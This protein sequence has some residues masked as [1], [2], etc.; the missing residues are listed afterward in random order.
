MRKYLFIAKLILI[1]S[2][3]SAQNFVS[4]D[5]LWN[6]RLLA[7][8]SFPSTEIFKI[9][10]DSIQNSIK[11]KKIW[12]SYD[13]TNSWVYQGL[14]R[15]ESNIV[16]FVPPNYDE[17]VLYDFNL[18]IGDTTYVK[19]IFCVD[20]EVEVIVYD[21]DTVTYLGMPR[22][23][24]LIN[25]MM[26]EYWIEGIGSQYGPL[27]SIYYMCI[28]CPQWDLLCYFR[29]EQLFYIMPGQ[30]KCF[31]TAVG[32]EEANSDDD[33]IITPNPVLKGEKIE[34]KSLE[35]IKGILI[36]NSSGVLIKSIVDNFNKRILLET[37]RFQ[38]GIYL[39]RIEAINNKTE[40]KRF[41]II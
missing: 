11:Y 12:V 36:Y 20:T 3:S 4:E 16:Y 27:Y 6:V 35:N 8:G 7:F 18:E 24:W 39:I 26:Q 1:I 31:Q 37:G 29:N 5:V 40:T 34:I 9:Q 32:V 38:R 13:S 21:I 2:V 30:T 14:L 23:R 25:E 41:I 15:E 28:A 10:G 17:G 22:K 33:I 19:N